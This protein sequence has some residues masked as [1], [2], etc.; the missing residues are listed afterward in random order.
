VPI[1]QVSAVP[2]DVNS[3]RQMLTAFDNQDFTIF[4]QD[5]LVESLIEIIENDPADAP[6]HDRVVGGA[7]AVLGELRAEG[8]VDLLIEH[9]DS[10]TTTCLYWLGTYATSESI[11]AI[12]EYLGSDDPSVRYEAAAALSTIPLDGL[13]PGTVEIEEDLLDAVNEAVEMINSRLEVEEDP[14]VVEA[15]TLALEQISILD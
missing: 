3:V 13:T 7:L 9:L 15:L 2:T 5:Q 4:D 8:A 11:L 6:Y 12:V 1:A 10:Y 14:S